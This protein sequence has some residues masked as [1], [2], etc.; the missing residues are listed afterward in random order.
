MI[1]DPLEIAGVIILIILL[2]I[3]I[4]WLEMRDGLR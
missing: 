1:T 3:G 2:T 4:R